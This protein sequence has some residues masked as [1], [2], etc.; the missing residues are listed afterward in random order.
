MGWALLWCH[1]AIQQMLM[2]G[3]ICWEKVLKIHQRRRIVSLLQLVL[4]PTIASHHHHHHY[5]YHRRKFVPDLNAFS[6][7]VF[8]SDSVFPFEMFT[9][10]NVRNPRPP[11]SF[12]SSTLF[13]CS[14]VSWPCFVT[15][16]S[17]YSL[18]EFIYDSLLMPFPPSILLWM[19]VRASYYSLFMN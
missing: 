7:F 1:D 13:D 3:I 4:Q 14:A 16:P 17:R 10:S 6:L 18:S 12:V 9:F 2:N 11:P 19:E 8:C 5:H 15:L